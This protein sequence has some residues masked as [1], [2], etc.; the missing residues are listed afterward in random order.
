MMEDLA[1][2]SVSR[3]W[4]GKP[5]AERPKCPACGKPLQSN[6]EKKRRLTTIGL[7]LDNIE[8]VVDKNPSKSHTYIAGMGQEI[9]PPQFLQSYWP[10][11]V[12]V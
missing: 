11:V 9:V 7:T 2:D 12:I 10:D 4:S 5:T 1:L 8:F 3:D 6:R